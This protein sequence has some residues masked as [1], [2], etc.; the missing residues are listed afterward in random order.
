MN[1]KMN[2]RDSIKQYISFCKHLVKTWQYLGVPDVSQMD[3][4]MSVQAVGVINIAFLRLCGFNCFW[5][6]I[7]YLFLKESLAGIHM[8][9]VLMTPGRRKLAG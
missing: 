3:N 2:T 5:E 7:W 8:L 9:R 1:F 6:S 4:E